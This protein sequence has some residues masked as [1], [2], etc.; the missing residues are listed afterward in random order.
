MNR[1]E[2]LRSIAV[3]SLCVAGFVIAT[4]TPL[5][6][7]APAAFPTPLAAAEALV[8]GV[9]RHDEAVIKATLGSDYA[10][11]LPRDATD[12][13]ITTFLEAWA[14]SHRI[15]AAGADKAWLEVGTN[16]WTVP[17]P[18]VKGASG[19]QFDVTAAKDEIVTRRIGRNELAAI[20][21]ALAYT[22]A[23]EEYAERDRNGDGVKEYA[24]KLLSSPGK[25]DGLYWPTLP[26]EPASPLGPIAAGAKPGAAF[27]G[28]AYR[29]LTGQGKDAPG[30][31]KS[32]A[33]AGRLTEGYGLVAWPAKYGDS[34]VMTFIVNQDGVVYQKDLGPRS[35]A[36]AKAMAAYN[37]DSTWT[38]AKH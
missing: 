34:G 38:K 20:E 4:G 8:D 37:P 30:G 36:L 5:A 19:W 6:S 13:E 17:I 3:R 14:R 15:V 10:R 35:A 16:G 29:I 1:I 9:A 24:A 18:L 26:G 25:R 11:Y 32:Y 23:Q 21:V 33:K 27:H 28:Y 7:A 31:A 22:D 12:E 2:F